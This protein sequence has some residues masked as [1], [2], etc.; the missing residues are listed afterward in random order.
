MKIYLLRHA[1][2]ES[3]E[4]KNYPNDDRP[5]T[6]EGRRKMSAAANGITKIAKHFDLI[7]S[8]PLVRAYDSAVIVAKA[9]NY[10]TKIDTCKLLLPGNSPHAVLSYLAKFNAKKNVL[11]V[12]HE[13]GLSMLA[14]ALLGYDKSVIEMKKGALCRIDADRLSTSKTAKLIWHLSPKQLRKLGS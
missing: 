6:E 12:G 9:V 8:S 4:G 1:I 10:K 14:S 13:P 5:L 7:I 11:L 3:R 2:A